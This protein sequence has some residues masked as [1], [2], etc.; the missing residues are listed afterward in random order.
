M[1]LFKLDVGEDEF[2]V[3]VIVI[4]IELRLIGNVEEFVL[5]QLLFQFSEPKADA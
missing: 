1:R 3:G 2:D 5:E 4:C